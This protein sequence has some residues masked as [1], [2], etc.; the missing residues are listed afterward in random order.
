MSLLG[1]AMGASLLGDFAG[2]RSRFESMAPLFQELG[3]RHRLNMVRS[4]LAHIDRREGNL[5]KAEA[6]YRETILAWKRLGH[7]AAIAHQLESFAYIAMRREKL[8]RAA[9]LFG[10]A[11][12]LRETI[13]ISMTNSEKIEYDAEVARLRSTLG[14]QAMTAE[15]HKGR[16]M[17]LDQAISYAIKP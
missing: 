3:D 15:W 5:D 13:G 16:I 12:A 1:M 6:A 2:A 9:Q 8:Q 14:D 11:E 10:A 4:E 17:S 7:R